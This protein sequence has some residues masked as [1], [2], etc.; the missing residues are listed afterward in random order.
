MV[1][2]R[3]L[4]IIALFLLL[5]AQVLAA[6]QECSYLQAKKDKGDS[7]QFTTD[8]A[9]GGGKIQITMGDL[10]SFHESGED[11]QVTLIN[12]SDES[13]KV[14]RE[15]MP[16][17]LWAVDLLPDM[18][19]YRVIISTDKKKKE[20]SYDPYIGTYCVTVA[21]A[22]DPD[23]EPEVYFDL[24][25]LSDVEQRD[26]KDMSFSAEI[27][28]PDRDEDGCGDKN[29]PTQCSYLDTALSYVA[30]GN[31]CNDN[32]SDFC[33]SC[34][35]KGFTECTEDNRYSIQCNPPVTGV[36]S[37]W[38]GE[39][40]FLKGQFSYDGQYPP[41]NAEPWKFGATDIS[42]HHIQAIQHMKSKPLDGNG[43]PM[44]DFILT[45]IAD[46]NL[47]Y[48]TIDAVLIDNFGDDTESVGSVI[49]RYNTYNPN[50]GEHNH[51]GGMQA[52]GEYL[53]IAMEGHN[54]EPQVRIVHFN[55][56]PVNPEF[57]FTGRKEI[58]TIKDYK[59]KASSVGVTK[60]DDESYLMAVCSSSNC[61][62]IQFYKSSMSTITTGIGHDLDWMGET[63]D[64]WPPDDTWPD[65]GP[66]GMN[67]LV[68]HEGKIYVAMF[69]IDSPD[70][71][72]GCASSTGKNVV[73][74]YQLETNF[75][76]EVEE[77]DPPTPPIKLNYLSHLV[78]Q[79][80]HKCDVRALPGSDL[81]LLNP[82]FYDVFKPFFLV[83][84]LGNDTSA[85]NFNAGGGLMIAPNGNDD[86]AF[87]GVEHYNSCGEELYISGFGPIYD[88]F[89]PVY[90]VTEGNTR[91]GVTSNVNVAP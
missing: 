29:E 43:G 26:V 60:L 23:S 14:W 20:K 36:T 22:W 53:F 90:N 12:L 15:K 33:D 38:E 25:P 8:D 57:D 5:P 80:K 52:I 6:K 18:G 83:Q 49:A 85:I 59:Y 21:A 40:Q 89:S 78:V 70:S 66:Q 65:C 69:G 71:I 82:L 72:G 45:S 86:I 7:F 17:N 54:K 48:P 34:E 75:S 32:N 76:K 51:P 1:T 28:Y 56:D 42:T 41:G 46:K 16:V 19:K 62:H 63:D 55:R 64:T 31:D 79:G 68:D 44:S 27:V 35:L 30:E 39:Y 24:R 81:V 61:E 58:T 73:Y 88:P 50:W 87:L 37:K 3:F 2:R 11:V 4:T 10:C 84:S 13:K 47:P 67:L 91:W 9:W 74:L 77:E